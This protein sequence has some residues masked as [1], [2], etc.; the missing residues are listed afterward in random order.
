MAYKKFVK[1]LKTTAMNVMGISRELAEG[2]V[3]EI[4][5]GDK[6]TCEQLMSFGLFRM[7]NASEIAGE[8]QIEFIPPPAPVNPSPPSIVTRISGNLIENT[9]EVVTEL[10]AKPATPSPIKS[11]P[12]SIGTTFFSC[13]VCGASFATVRGLSVHQSRSHK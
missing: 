10:E 8:S 4:D 2:D 3:N 1:M 6:V 9:A 12:S 11:E 7:A 5:F 13:G